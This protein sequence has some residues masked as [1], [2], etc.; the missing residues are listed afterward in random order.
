[1]AVAWPAS[2]LKQIF[3]RHWVLRGAMGA[4]CP[5]DRGI[6]GGDAADEDPPVS[7]AP[8]PEA[9]MSPKRYAVY[10]RLSP[11]HGQDDG[12]GPMGTD[13]ALP[14]LSLRIAATGSSPVDFLEVVCLGSETFAVAA[15]VGGPI[16]VIDVQRAAIVCLHEKRRCAGL[17]SVAVHA[18]TPHQTQRCLI[19][20]CFESGAVTLLEFSTKM[21]MRLVEFASISA[22][23][24]PVRQLE[25]QGENADPGPSVPA[26][27]A[28]FSP[29]LQ[30]LAVAYGAAGRASDSFVIRIFSLTTDSS[31]KNSSSSPVSLAY[32]CRGHLNISLGLVFLERS[33]SEI[34]LASGSHDHSTTLWKLPARQ[35][36]DTQSV[37]NA[38][39]LFDSSR[40]VATGN[41]SAPAERLRRTPA[42]VA[43]LC[44]S[45]ESVPAAMWDLSSFS[46]KAKLTKL[47]IPASFIV[48]IA[49]I[50]HAAAFVAC[51]NHSETR[52]KL[53]LL[54]WDRKTGCLLP[55]TRSQIALDVVPTC[56]SHASQRTDAAGRLQSSWLG[57]GRRDG[58]VEVY[59]IPP[60]AMGVVCVDSSTGASRLGRY[61]FCEDAA[62]GD[63][64]CFD[65][66]AQVKTSHLVDVLFPP[67]APGRAGPDNG[68]GDDTSVKVATAEPDQ[69][70]AAKRPRILAPGSEADGSL[71]TL[72]V[73]ID[74]DA[75]ERQIVA[76]LVASYSEALASSLLPAVA[77]ALQ[78]P[79]RQAILLGHVRQLVERS[80]DGLVVRPVPLSCRKLL[81]S[82]LADAYIVH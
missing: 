67:S 60:P 44:P 59:S 48:D 79:S 75:L 69:G 42:G 18:L 16:A 46:K 26:V 34:Y 25:G 5:V 58:L 38:A 11:G 70:P 64:F 14:S 65:V 4:I 15:A 37:Q 13:L 61:L 80:S 19:A 28:A 55:T 68:D 29:S 71:S 74:Q 52:A 41:V 6:G 22:F 40:S 43:A 53:L 47:S 49:F 12:A 45:K 35:G 7:I 56:L 72:Q 9:G 82:D 8:V 3:P 30:L 78:Q 57:V 33:P 20:A 17:L 23:P 21:R 50:S 63:I 62:S 39:I 10:S 73:A 66:A 51:V 32:I 81:A 2:R 36:R 24:V 1:M 27:A 31:S 76:D 54:G 77:G